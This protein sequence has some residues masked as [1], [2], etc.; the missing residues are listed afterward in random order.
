VECERARELIDAYLDREL[1]VEASTEIERHIETC[2][3]CRARYEGRRALSAHL[4]EPALYVAAP[5]GL[6]RRIADAIDAESPPA[7]RQP[8]RRQWLQL[9]AA[10]AAAAVLGSGTTYLSLTN[11][12]RSSLADEVVANHVRSLLVENRVVDVPSS[13][14]H[15]VKPW[16][17]GKLDFAPP[18]VDLT[19]DGFPLVGG[20]LDYAGQRTVAALVYRHRQHI[21]NL[22]LWPADDGGARGSAVSAESRQ[23]YHVLHWSSGGMVYWAVSDLN[24]ADLKAFGDLIQRGAAAGGAPE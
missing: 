5:N 23:G 17:N 6:R 4:K 18:V 14:E 2:A 12:S 3:A 10:C 20:R 15:T 11:G 16:F 19:S 8:A 22:F 9:A 13:D 1:A 21:I 24:P 7:A